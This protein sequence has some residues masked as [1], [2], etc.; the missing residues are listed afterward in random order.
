MNSFFSV[1]KIFEDQIAE[2]TGKITP[3]GRR[4][5]WKKKEIRLVFATPEVVKNDIQEN[6]LSLTDFTLLVFD[7]SHRAVKDYAYSYV[8]EEYVKQS[9]CPK[10]WLLLPVQVRKNKGS[11]MFVI[12][13]SLNR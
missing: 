13:C 3:A 2:V 12:I 8:A 11:R 9:V 1:L 6:R 5:I 4:A 10:S 7:E